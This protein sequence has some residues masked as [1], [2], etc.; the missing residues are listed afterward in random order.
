VFLFGLH[1]ACQNRPSLRVKSI[2]AHIAPHFARPRRSEWQFNARGLC[3]R[4]R[5]SAAMRQVRH[6]ATLR[7]VRPLHLPRLAM[8]ASV[9]AMRRVL[10][11]RYLKPSPNQD[12]SIRP[13]RR[14]A[15]VLRVPSC[16]VPPSCGHFLP[17]HLQHKVNVYGG[18]GQ[19]AD[20]REC[21]GF[22]AAIALRAFRSSIRRACLR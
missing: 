22:K 9:A 4:L 20:F 1:A 19:R 16:A 18:N 11:S 2:S 3:L 14:L 21:V 12:S 7:D 15:F 17:K 10:A 5:S 13:R 8:R 6:T